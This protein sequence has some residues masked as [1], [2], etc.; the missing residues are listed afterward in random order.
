LVF[1]GIV[2]TWKSGREF[3]LMPHQCWE[4]VHM[5]R[6]VKMRKWNCRCGGRQKR[7][8][9]RNGS[10]QKVYLGHREKKNEVTIYWDCWLMTKPQLT[11]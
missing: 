9:E 8:P 2:K 4:S 1:A 11:R 10:I 3:K 5:C 7:S 6:E